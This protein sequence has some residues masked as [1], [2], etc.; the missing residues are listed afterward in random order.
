MNSYR[1]N[2]ASQSP[3]TNLV[4]DPV[5]ISYDFSNPANTFFAADRLVCLDPVS[6]NG[7]VRH[8]ILEYKRQ[9]AFS[10]MMR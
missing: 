10:K 3:E 1:T 7:L 4:G 8:K 6:G 2:A 9:M 5:D